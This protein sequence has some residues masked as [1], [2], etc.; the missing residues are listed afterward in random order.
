MDRGLGAHADGRQTR[1]TL[2]VIELALLASSSSVGVQHFAPS[3][4]L[5]ELT[6]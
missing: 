6:E 3:E 1:Y 5:V 4:P 2:V